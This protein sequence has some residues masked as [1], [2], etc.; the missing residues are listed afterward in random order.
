MTTPSDSTARFHLATKSGR[1]IGL[2][3]LLF[4]V[5]TVGV[6]I[7]YGK[8]VSFYRELKSDLT[9][10]MPATDTLVWSLSA[11][12]LMQS[13]YWLRYR[14]RPAMPG[15]VHVL[16]GHFVRFCARLLFVL[17]TAVFSFVVIES[18]LKGLM[19]LPRYLLVFLALFSLYCYTLELERL[20]KVLMG[21]KQ[22][23]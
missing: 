23:T 1:G 14:L 3:L 21:Q 5:Q 18:K 2:Y 10:Y 12:V 9:T 8:G 17:P 7:F 15:S 4:A 11:I 16:L 13:G 19:P 22:V 6:V 20:G